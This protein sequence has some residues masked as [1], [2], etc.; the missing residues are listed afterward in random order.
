MELLLCFLANSLFFLLCSGTWYLVS[1]L[2]RVL[3]ILV[4]KPWSLF[5][6]TVSVLAFLLVSVVSDIRAGMVL[7]GK[8]RSGPELGNS[9]DTGVEA[10]IIDSSKVEAMV[11]SS[12]SETQK[13]QLDKARWYLLLVKVNSA[14][15]RFN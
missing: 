11:E 6:F 13:V 1:N 2:V 3:T 9:L 5:F 14:T 4:M 10:L 7:E 15:L 8:V 12:L